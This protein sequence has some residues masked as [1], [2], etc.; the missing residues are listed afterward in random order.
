MKTRLA[1][2]DE[3]IVSADQLFRRLHNALESGAF[4]SAT[5]V[6]PPPTDVRDRQTD[7]QTDH[8]RATTAK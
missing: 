7:R 8:R 1:D 2:C 5:A 4:V 3:L 6:P